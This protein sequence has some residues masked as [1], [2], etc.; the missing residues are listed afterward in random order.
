MEKWALASRK[1]GRTVNPEAVN[2]QDCMEKWQYRGLGVLLNDGRVLGFADG[3]G[4]DL[5]NSDRERGK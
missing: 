2:I 1:E 5:D 3:T 4:E